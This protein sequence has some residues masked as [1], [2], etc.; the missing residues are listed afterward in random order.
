[1]EGT[2][3]ATRA[4]RKQKKPKIVDPP[5]EIQS[6]FTMDSSFQTSPFIKSELGTQGNPGLQ[7]TMHYNPLSMMSNNMHGGY[8]FPQDFASTQFQ[9]ASS[10]Q[11][12]PPSSSSPATPSSFMNSYSSENMSTSY[13][14]SSSVT[15][16]DFHFRDVDMQNSCSNLLS[17]IPWDP[18]ASSCREIP[19]IKAEE[20]Q[21]GIQTIPWEPLSSHQ[22]NCM[23]AT[24]VEQY[25][26][27]NAIT[28]GPPSPRY[29]QHQNSPTDI[30][31]SRLL[32]RELSPIIKSEKQQEENRIFTLVTT[33]APPTPQSI[34]ATHVRQV[35]QNN[36]D[37]T[38]DT[39]APPP[40]DASADLEQPLSNAMVIWQPPALPCET[41]SA[42]EA[43]KQR[44][45]NITTEPQPIPS[46]RQSISI[47]DLEEEKHSNKAL[48]MGERT[49]QGPFVEA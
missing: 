3:G 5:A 49:D 33:S 1:M 17:T 15:Q 27:S 43:A 20:S 38:W 31:D 39:L 26:P 42:V 45:I 19:T 28:W 25:Q 48:V 12:M 10:I 22:P 13:P 21:Q 24:S 7:N 14:Y 47:G 18:Q 40:E 32:P 23:T 35:Y 29:E 4:K 34:P 36:R 46:T 44:D 6:T 2:T 16:S 8:Y 41:A 30:C 11:S 9:M 37:I